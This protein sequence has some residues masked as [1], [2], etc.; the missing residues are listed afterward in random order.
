MPLVLPMSWPNIVDIGEPYT[1][2]TQLIE[3][4]ERPGVVQKG[5]ADNLS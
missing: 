4:C 2:E 5:V 3:A 1:C